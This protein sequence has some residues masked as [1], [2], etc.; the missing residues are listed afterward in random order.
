[1]DGDLWKWPCHHLN[2]TSK[3]L[4]F[5]SLPCPLSPT[6]SPH[7]HNHPSSY[8]SLFYIAYFKSN[9]SL[10][11]IQDKCIGDCLSELSSQLGSILITKQV[12][13]NLQ[14]LLIPAI[15]GCIRNMRH[16]VEGRS[17]KQW[18]IESN[19]EP[20][21]GTFDEYNEMIIQFGYVTLFVAAFPM[22]PV[23]ALINN[24]VEQHSDAYKLLT[25][26]QRPAAERAEDLGS[27]YSIL[28]ALSV[29]GVLTNALVIAFTS[30]QLDV[31]LSWK[32]WTVFI[33]EHSVLL[34][35][36]ALAALI[37]D[38]PERIQD[39]IEKEEYQMRLALERSRGIYHFSNDLDIIWN[40]DDSNTFSTVQREVVGTNFHT[41]EILKLYPVSVVGDVDE[42]FRQSERQRAIES[43]DFD[44]LRQ[45]RKSSTDV[46]AAKYTTAKLKA[47]LSRNKHND[48]P[49]TV[50]MADLSS[51]KP[52]RSRVA[53]DGGES[54]VSEYSEYDDVS[55]IS[56][57]SATST[58]NLL[59]K[60]KK[61][62]REPKVVVEEKDGVTTTTTTTVE[63][64]P[65]GKL[66]KVKRIVRRTSKKAA[67]D[68]ASTGNTKR[69]VRRVVSTQRKKHQH[70][71]EEEDQ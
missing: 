10:F 26:Y 12:I 67:V 53:S 38:I 25:S 52:N 16:S 40:P 41:K 11:G 2:E 68:M 18:E 47:K 70:D 3:P 57:M 34:L 5:P 37:P 20:F 61:K 6:L 51:S 8:I 33:F 66:R 24:L 7:S 28:D 43:G 9:A 45:N 36:V 55:V 4:P 1:M 44:R 21:P 58:S 42:I 60:K 13:G 64:G 71:D 65:D 23:L 17:M 54:H 30:E 32:F 49:V 29:I 15:K 22:A 63:R 19:L 27:W 62:N 31:T 59:A 48:E 35:K 56:D 39:E 69:I 50:E 14:E 46:R